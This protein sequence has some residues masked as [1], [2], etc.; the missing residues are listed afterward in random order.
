MVVAGIKLTTLVFQLDRHFRH[1][2]PV[3]P[4]RLRSLVMGLVAALSVAAVQI[5]AVCSFVVYLFL[6]IDGPS[7]NLSFVE[8]GSICCCR[9]RDQIIRVG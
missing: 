2:Q 5:Y 8:E 4:L 3:S 7:N 6:G 1:T 9:V